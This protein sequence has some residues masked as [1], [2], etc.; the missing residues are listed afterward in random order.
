MSHGSATDATEESR[1]RR[2]NLGVPASMEALQYSSA[3]SGLKS[4]REG[5]E[6]VR[7]LGL[8]SANRDDRVSP[9][10]ESL[11]LRR[12]PEPRMEVLLSVGDSGRLEPGKRKCTH[13]HG[14]CVRISEIL[15]PSRHVGK[16]GREVKERAESGRA[17]KCFNATLLR[18]LPG[19]H[20]A[21]FCRVF[22]R[23][24]R[25]RMQLTRQQWNRSGRDM[26]MQARG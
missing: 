8:S 3:T 20:I 19:V 9:Y 15:A 13:I 12:L 16:E 14:A 17:L 6:T 18:A 4:L 2:S 24:Q 22:G 7:Y 1:L 10:H 23:F 25:A 11:V 21:G 26:H 5:C